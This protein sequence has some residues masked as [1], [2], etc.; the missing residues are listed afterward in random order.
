ME[1]GGAR[2]PGPGEGF[3]LQW[4]PHSLGD[5]SHAE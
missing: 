2:V 5:P 4:E 3:E 1:G